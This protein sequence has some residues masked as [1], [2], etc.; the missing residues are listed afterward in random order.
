M[1]FYKEKLVRYYNMI[2]ASQLEHVEIM[3]EKY[4]KTGLEMDLIAEVNISH[5]KVL[6]KCAFGIDLSGEIL[7]WEEDGVTTKKTLDYVMI[8]SFHKLF[9]RVVSLQILVFPESHEWYIGR[10]HREIRR[11][12]YRLRALF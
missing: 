4:V 5:I 10:A 7:D 2:K 8:T 9:M 11:N 6:L 3:R 1:S 12:V